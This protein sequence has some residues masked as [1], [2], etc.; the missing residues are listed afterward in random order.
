[1]TRSEKNWGYTKCATSPIW[2]AEPLRAI[3]M[4]VG[5]LHDVRTVVICSKFGVDRSTG[6][7]S[8]DP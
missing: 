3:V 4:K 6:F 8:A 5:V 1:V 7:E 2:A